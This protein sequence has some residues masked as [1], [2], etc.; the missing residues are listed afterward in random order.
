MVMGWLATTYKHPKTV[1]A[2]L[3]LWGGVGR[4]FK[5][6]KLPINTQVQAFYNVEKPDTIGPE[7]TL[8]VQLQTL[9]P[10]SIFK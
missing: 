1:P 5:I 10:K 4:L 2:S 6:G 7:W 3:G 8:R 9:L